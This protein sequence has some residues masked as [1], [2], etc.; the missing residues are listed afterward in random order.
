MLCCNVSSS[1]SLELE[2]G[3]EE[4]R[5]TKVKINTANKEELLTVPGL[6]DKMA[7]FILMLRSS[8]T[9]TE[10]MLGKTPGFTEK[11]LES[12]D[13]TDERVYTAPELLAVRRD[14]EAKVKYHQSLAKEKIDGDKMNFW[15]FPPSLASDDGPLEEGPRRKLP[16][17]DSR[18]G[19]INY[20]PGTQQESRHNAGQA[21]LHQSEPC[22]PDS[23][24]LRQAKYAPGDKMGVNPTTQYGT[25]PDGNP[26]FGHRADPQ[27]QPMRQQWGPQDPPAPGRYERGNVPL[28]V[29]PEGHWAQNAPNRNLLPKDLRFEGKPNTLSWSVFKARFNRFLNEY[30]VAA[31]QTQLFYLGES[32]RAKA[33]DFF[34]SAQQQRPFHTLEEAF[35]HLGSRFDLQ[36]N[37]EVALLRLQGMQQGSKDVQSFAEDIWETSFKA[38]PDSS[39]REKERQAVNHFTWGLKDG[40]ARS[41]VACHQPTTMKE[42]IKLA[43]VYQHSKPGAAT[44]TPE[45]KR[46]MGTPFEQEHQEHHGGGVQP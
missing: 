3:M 11:I 9:I 39:H 37:P 12:F 14:Q 33:C 45:V 1:S 10:E 44:K 42:A 32:L 6:G 27:F 41:T 28:A 24:A 23:R 30:Q 2:A 5:P 4:P 8:G 17:H 31:P 35:H 20:T 16:D 38:F 34:E 46:V 7:L 26:G 13:F 18:I 43:V 25:V 22:L 29:R 36:E 19:Q 21:A 15:S 40:N